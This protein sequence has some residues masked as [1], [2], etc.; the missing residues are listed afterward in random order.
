[1][2]VWLSGSDPL[3][4]QTWHE[5]ASCR[6]L[7]PDIFY[8]VTD[9]DAESAKDVCTACTVRVSCLEYALAARE[10]EGVWGGATER[11]RRR[12]IRQRRRTA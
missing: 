11:D 3:M 2:A 9:E 8:P 5:Q 4:K 7:D 10:V 6:G 12:M 1:M